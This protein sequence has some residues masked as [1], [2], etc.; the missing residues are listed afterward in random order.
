MS[1]SALSVRARLAAAA[2]HALTHLVTR[3]GKRLTEGPRTSAADFRCEVLE[4][5]FLLQATIDQ[6]NFCSHFA[7]APHCTCCCCNNQEVTQNDPNRSGAYPADGGVVAAAVRVGPG[8]SLIYSGG[9]VPIAGPGGGTRDRGTY[10]PPGAGGAGDAGMPPDSADDVSFSDYPI[11]YLNGTPKFQITDLSSAGFGKTWGQI[12]S[13][14]PYMSNTGIMGNHWTTNQLPHLE[15]EGSNADSGRPNGATDTVVAYSSG[16]DQRFFDN[17]PGQGWVERYGG[18]DILQS[19]GNVTLANTHSVATL[20][21]IDTTGCVTTFDD[22]TST[23]PT[24]AEQSGQFIS[25]N[26]TYGNVTQVTAYDSTTYNIGEVQ[27][28]NGQIVESWKYTYLSGAPFT[29]SGNVV[30]AN[31]LLRRSTNGGSSWTNVRQV[32]YSFYDGSATGPMKYGNQGD[33]RSAV[34]SN[35][36]TA[37]SGA[38]LSYSGTTVTVN[39]SNSYVSGDTIVVSGASQNAANGLWVISNVTSTS[40]TYTIGQSLTGTDTATVNK[41]FDVSFYRYY[42]PN[43]D[44]GNQYVQGQIKYVLGPQSYARARAAGVDPSSVVDTS[45]DG[46]ADNKFAYQ[47]DGKVTDEWVQGGTVH[48]QYRYFTNGSPGTGYNAW[49]NGTQETLPDGTSNTIYGD[50]GGLVMMEVHADS[51]GNQWATYLKYDTSGRLTTYALPSSIS[52]PSGF[53]TTVNL[54]TGVVTN[55]TDQN[56][57]DLVDYTG[58]S[59]L[60][61]NSGLVYS[62]DYYGSGAVGYF[63]DLYVQNG[64]GGTLFKL[65]HMTYTSHTN[66]GITI[67]PKASDVL[68]GQTGSGDAR[69][70]SYAYTFYSNTNMPL[71]ITVT[72]PSTSGQNGPSTAPSNTET[73]DQYGRVYQTQDGDG[74]IETTTYDMGTGAVTQ[75]V[76]DSATGGLKLTT[77]YTVDGLGRPTREIDPGG[78]VTYFVYKDANHE[79]RTY[80]GLGFYSQATTN[81]ATN[82]IIDTNLTGTSYVGDTLVVIGGTDSG[83]NAVITGYNSSTHTLTFIPNLPSATDASTQFILVGS[84]TTGPIQVSREYRPAPSA[85]SGQQ[86]VYDETLTSSATPTVSGGFPTGTETIDQTNI[87][88]LSRS[89]TDS[90]G[91]VTE[92]DAYSS[93]SGLTYSTAYAQLQNAVAGSKTAAGNYSASLFGYDSTGRLNHQLSP[94]GTITDTTYDSLSRPVTI[95]VGTID[96]GGSQ[97]MVDVEDLQ[98]DNGGVGDSTLT[99]ATDHVD[100]SSLTATDNRVTLNL[101]DWRDRLIATKAGALIGSNGSPNPA[102]ETDSAHRLITFYNRDN[103]GEVTGTYLYA[104]DGVNLNDF[105]TWTDTGT[106]PSKMRGWQSATYDDIGRVY[107]SAVHSIDPTNGV[108]GLTEAQ[109]QALATLTTNYFYD[110]RGDLI[111][112]SDPGGLVYKHVYDGA[113]RD[114]KDSTTDG[115]ALNNSSQSNTWAAAST[116]QYDIVLEQTLNTYNADGLLIETVRRQRFD[117]DP[118]SSSGDGDL[119]GPSGGNL[120]SR[121]YYTGMYYD[122]ADRLTDSVNVGTNGGSAWTMPATAPAGSDTVLVTHTDYN[123]AGWLLDTIDPRGIKTGTFYDMLGRQTETI[124]AWDGTQN[125]TAGSSTNQETQY[126]YDANGDVLTMKALQPPGTTPADHQTTQYVYGVGGTAGTNLFSND[127]I[128]TVEYP[129]KSTGNA[130]T[131]AANDQSFGYNWQADKT[132]FTDQNG[133]THT[134]TYDVLDRLTLDSAAVASGDPQGVD[135]T[136]QSLGYSFDTA[137]RAYQQTSYAGL[138]GTGLA[139]NQVTDTYNGFGQL[140]SQEQ[141]IGTL[142]TGTVSYGYSSG[143]NYSR[144]SSITYPSTR[145]ITYG[146]NSGLD[147]TISRVSYLADGSTHLEEYTYLGLAT[148]VQKNHPQS[149]V[150][151]TYIQQTGEQNVITDGG[152][153]YTGLDRFGRVVDE[154]WVNPSTPTSPTDRFQYGYDRD[155]NVLYKNNLVSG[156][157][158]EL[159]H[160]NAASSGDDNTAYDSLG[161]LTGFRRGTLS[162]SSFNNGV[163]DTVSTLNTLGGSSNSWSLDALG[164]WTST[165]GGSQTRGFNAQNQITSITSLTTPVYDNNGNMVTDEA[166]NNYTYDAWNRQIGVNGSGEMYLYDAIGRRPSLTLSG[167]GL[168]L[169]YFSADWQV[170]EDDQGTSKTTYVWSLSYIDDMV[171]RDDG[172]G[173]RLYAQTDVDHNVTALVDTTGAVKER[174]VYDPYGT[175]TVLSPSWVT[176]AD[177]YAWVYMFQGGRYDGISGLYNFRSRDYRPSLGV[178]M[179]KDTGFWNGA[180]LYQLEGSNPVTRVDPLGRGYIPDPPFP[181]PG[182]P[183][184]PEGGPGPG[185]SPPIIPVGKGGKGIPSNPPPPP[186]E[187]PPEEEPPIDTGPEP[188]PPFPFGPGPWGGGELVEVPPEPGDPPGLRRL[189][190]IPY[191]PPDEP[192][193]RGGDNCPEDFRPHGLGPEPGL[194]GDGPPVITLPPISTAPTTPTA[195][196]SA[197]TAPPSTP[198]NRIPPII[199]PPISPIRNPVV[200]EPPP[201]VPY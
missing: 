26:D 189:R 160:A 52:L 146:Y 30:L 154:Y 83:H 126:T 5:R 60:S 16:T 129:D 196:P 70:T 184:G 165:A 64:S 142:G 106:D 169:S 77:N 166:N 136:V 84:A 118:T 75:T 172:S 152:P 15:D 92:T 69:T 66:S 107:Q 114:T 12:R 80:P 135:T 108:S 4:P 50:A 72:A 115:S 53:R 199:F 104:G 19:G 2:G 124:G 65:E 14:D 179:E 121:D 40:F 132:S 116:E 27:R 54:S 41:P 125:P 44:G 20:K 105:A 88:T 25:F 7:D 155:G 190:F 96:T 56:V 48:Y 1:A 138:S 13:Y 102:G 191:A 177:Q 32:D 182:N 201:E 162:A 164:N 37:I 120:A 110:K 173:T 6:H 197:P 151:L 78:D 3:A 161:R 187:P 29:S 9:S 74:Y 82:T 200:P 111:E 122:A 85:G 31:V 43:D 95:K 112:Q 76:V 141:A 24:T 10:I 33:L 119:A 180:D 90:T 163:L 198:P 51:S 28:V 11:R 67:Y 133:T 130:S 193:D 34:I 39:V 45:V 192:I 101:Y 49:T 93:L 147:S 170:L 47:S 36:N 186:E 159:Y 79:E 62:L 59:Y 148:I 98:Y 17:I 183:L 71:T 144:L 91:R 68:Y 140:L 8:G 117:N 103:L 81:G 157:F 171:A 100:N 35:P 42:T 89:L 57:S 99:R 139:V 97:N 63:D 22:P 194:P 61:S 168:T 185:G 127:L 123:A 158:S 46:Y 188:E 55:G 94:N 87:Q 150:E 23:D 156:T 109:I 113:G 176:T 143:T 86:T 153:R 21:L 58:G 131:A 178:W 145:V 73:L 38:S 134:Y 195:P 137:G 175:V 18:A 174:F 128:A 149:G 181:P 167:G